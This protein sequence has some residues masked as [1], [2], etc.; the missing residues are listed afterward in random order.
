MSISKTQI[1][2][3]HQAAKK[4]QERSYS[5]YSNYKVGCAILMPDETIYTGCNIENGSYGAVM[6]AERV[7]LFKMRSE[8]DEHPVAIMVITKNGASACGQCLQVIAELAPN[9]E[10]IFS[11]SDMSSLERYSLQQLWTAPF[12]LNK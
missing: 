9:A 4:G 2:K 12:T 11:D 6:C 7:A 8:T 3:L 1:V 10:L 5:P